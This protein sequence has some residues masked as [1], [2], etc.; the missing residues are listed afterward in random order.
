ME[1]A[2]AVVVEGEFE[3]A[4]EDEDELIIAEKAKIRAHSVTKNLNRI[5]LEQPQM[6]R[7]N[8]EENHALEEAHRSLQAQ[9][10][11][12]VEVIEDEDDATEAAEDVVVEEE[13]G[14]GEGVVR[15][16]KKKTRIKM[17]ISMG[18]PAIYIVARRRKE[19]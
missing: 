9:V 5:Q 6:M 13:V 8:S 2:E 11:D 16:K 4:G 7:K 10:E 18:K 1:L 12:E 3:E 19:K 15:M 14:S 17:M